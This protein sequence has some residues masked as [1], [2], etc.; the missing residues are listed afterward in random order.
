[1]GLR[2]MEQDDAVHY[3]NIYRPMEHKLTQNS[4]MQVVQTD[5]SGQ[6]VTVQMHYEVYLQTSYYG[7]FIIIL[8]A[9]VLLLILMTFV[10]YLRK[11]YTSRFDERIT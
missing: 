6:Q 11:R 10:N 3:L 2:A 8:T 4:Q 7:S 5:G 1:V 9:S